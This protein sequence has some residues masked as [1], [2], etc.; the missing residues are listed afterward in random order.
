MIETAPI[1]AL[2]TLFTATTVSSVLDQ[3][4][5]KQASFHRASL[6]KKP[7]FS[8]LACTQN[9]PWHSINDAQQLYSA[10][11]QAVCGQKTPSVFEILLH[12]AKLF[13]HTDG[14]TLVC[15]HN[16]FIAWREAAH[17]IGQSAFICA[18]WAWNDINNGFPHRFCN[19]PPY[20]QTDNL[21]LKQL[22]S[23]GIAEN[24]FHLKGSAPVFLLSWTCLMNNVLGRKKEFNS[25]IFRTR[26][27][28][29]SG[30][31]SLHHRVL[32]A[33][34]IRSYLFLP[35]LHRFKREPFKN[36]LR[37]PELFAHQLQQKIGVLRF[38]NPQNRLDYAG[39][40]NCKQTPYGAIQGEHTFLYSMFRKLY[41]NELSDW[42]ESLFYAYLL[43]S[44]QMRRELVQANNAVGFANFSQYQDRKELFLENYGEYKDALVRMA[45]AAVLSNQSVVSLEARTTPK[46]SP[47]ALTISHK[48]IEQLAFEANSKECMG[49]NAQNG[50]TLLSNGLQK[51][52]VFFDRTRHA[53]RRNVGPCDRPLEKISYVQHFVKLPDQSI[54]W[55]SPTAKLKCLRQY[56][57]FAHIQQQVE[58]PAV[59]IERWRDFGGAQAAR[60][61]GIDACNFEIGCRPE[62]FAPVFR[63]LR[64][65]TP[66]PLH[67]KLH[68]WAI[69]TLRVTYH[70]GEDFLDVVDGLRAIDEAIHFL[71]M[72]HGDR[73]GHAIALGVDAAEWYS[74]K[75][76][77]IYLP[78]HDLLDNISWLYCRLSKYNLCSN[79]LSHRLTSDYARLFLKIYGAPSVPITVYFDTWRLRGNHPRY[80]FSSK[81]NTY[82]LNR[83][84]LRRYKNDIQTITS[85][86]SI[87]PCTEAYNLMHRYHYDPNV[88]EIGERS[89]EYQ[90]IPAYRDAVIE[91]QKIMRGYIARK[92]IGI[93]TNPSSNYLIGTYI[94]AISNCKI[95]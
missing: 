32:Q 50:T 37:F 90:I 17:S 63:R 46:K 8:T 73:L 49:A 29:N 27:F 70:V 52:C 76:N 16:K 64:R 87:A 79:T 77:I 40:R 23:R 51:P 31:Y 7:D 81:E 89:Q 24:H 83:T 35:E 13:L 25:P 4:L 21:R 15:Y 5:K 86:N 78:M 57:H 39:P 59:A 88:R 58:A 75:K 36:Y 19:F 82:M 56:R 53:C 22:L 93:E 65:H 33:A 85:A 2:H 91:M 3:L 74:F 45:H 72:Q 38:S 95:L 71:E 92:G 84:K 67:N 11:Q 60:V 18:Y 55:K 68:P 10:T 47:A 12:V 9:Y 30:K 94:R 41:S 6:V 48:K 43:I 62:V 14:N 44:T 69:P 54:N 1:H 61:Y 80:F 42:D 26:F 34:F 20:A 28:R 66:P